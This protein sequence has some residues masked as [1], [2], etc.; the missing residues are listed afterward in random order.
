MTIWDTIGSF[1]YNLS[2]G[3]LTIPRLLCLGALVIGYFFGM[4]QTAYFI[5]KLKHVDIYSEGS[6]NPGTTNM[7]RVMGVGPGIVTFVLDIGKVVAATFLTQFLFFTVFHFPVDPIALKLYT[8]LGAVLGHN[9]PVYLKGKGGK[10]VASTIAVIFCLGEW[11]YIVVWAVVF[12]VVFLLTRYVSFASMASII[13]VMFEFL[14]FTLMNVTYV[15]SKWMI[16]TH[17]IMIL[18][19]VLVIV[20]H[21]KNI[22]RI[23]Y[24]EESKF[25]FRKKKEEPEESFEESGEDVIPEVVPEMVEEPNAEAQKFLDDAEALFAEHAEFLAEAEETERKEKEK[26]ENV[27]EKSQ[28]EAVVS[29]TERVEEKSD[30]ENK[31]NSEKSIKTRELRT[32]HNKAAQQKKKKKSSSKK[33]RKNNSTKKKRKKNSTKKKRK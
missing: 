14:L 6:G 31:D 12:V 22:I 30:E 1:F 8:G 9:F 32:N 15:S 21:R 28:E 7:F 19:S 3:Y 20:T 25:T 23:L 16:D 24:G 11:K 13:A 18:L 10:G 27:P 2:L 33:K 17:V 29:V 26:A 5:S 4:F